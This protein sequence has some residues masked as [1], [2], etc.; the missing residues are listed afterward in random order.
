MTT[1]DLSGTLLVSCS[2][3]NCDDIVKEAKKKPN[4]TYVFKPREHNDVDIVVNVSGS[5]E[6]IFRVKDQIYNISNVKSIK[7]TITEK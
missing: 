2:G 5:K 7:Y 1:A 3:N 4:V 6:D